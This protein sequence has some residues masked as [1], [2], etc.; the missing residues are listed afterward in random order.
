MILPTPILESLADP[1]PQEWAEVAKYLDHNP[2]SPE[3]LQALQKALRKWP[4]EIPRDPLK[5]WVEEQLTRGY[6]Q[7]LRLCLK[8]PEVT[9]YNYYLAQIH[10]APKL[11]LS[12][13]QPAVRLQRFFS[14]AAKVNDSDAWIKIGQAGQAD[15]VGMTTLEMGAIRL[16]VYTELEIKMPKGYQSDAQKVREEVVKGRGGIY[17]VA[18]SVKAAVAGLVE[19]RERL[20]SQL[21]ILPKSWVS[22]ANQVPLQL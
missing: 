14:G 8:V 15:L 10:S 22:N 3:L 16:A 6:G 11:Q 19:E 20:L 17:L 2:P 12:T 18:K 1:S 5:H 9:T 13:G 21:D 4:R 7:L